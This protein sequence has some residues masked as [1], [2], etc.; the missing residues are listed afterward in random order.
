[1]RSDLISYLTVI[2]L[3]TW[4]KM[5]ISES[6]WNRNS[7][8]EEDMQKVYQFLF[9]KF[10]NAYSYKELKG[11]IDLP[12][13]EN[14]PAYNWT[15]WVLLVSRLQRGRKIETKNIDGQTYYRAKK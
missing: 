9:E 2:R 3:L 7:G 14:I 6:K 1:M 4:W 13:E 5:P 8:Q 11:V 15:Y 10:P 12:K